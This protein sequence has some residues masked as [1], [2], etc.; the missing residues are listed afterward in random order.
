MMGTITRCHCPESYA[1]STNVKS[2]LINPSRFINHHCPDFFLVIL[3]TGGPP[4]L[5]N[6][7]AYHPINKPPVLK[8]LFL[9]KI[10]YFQ[11][12]L[13][14]ITPP[15]L[16]FIFFTKN[17]YFQFFWFLIMSH[18]SQNHEILAIKSRQLQWNLLG[19]MRF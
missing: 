13:I 2:G 6:S 12:F 3:K 10:F 18:E 14:L 4:G 16:K 9:S 8:F 15:V 17:I 5:K 1:F 19:P 11:F 7:L